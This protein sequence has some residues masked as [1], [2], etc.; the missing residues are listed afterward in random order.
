MKWRPTLLLCLI[1]LTTVVKGQFYRLS[2]IVMDGKKEPL[3]LS[4]IEIK[5]TRKGSVTKDDGSY[6][7]FLE[8]GQYNLVVSMVGFKTRIVEVFIT[9][10]DVVENVEME[11]EES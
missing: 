11:N 1:L 3:P 9:N 4:T 5:E 7:F 10:A 8:R 6:E 2:G